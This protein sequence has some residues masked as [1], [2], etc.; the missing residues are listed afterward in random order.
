MAIILRRKFSVRMNPDQINSLF[1]FMEK[2]K[3]LP[4]AFY[5]QLS[6]KQSQSK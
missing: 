1:T 5:A 2:R 4:K 6:L 3:K